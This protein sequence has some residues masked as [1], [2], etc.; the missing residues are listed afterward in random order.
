[1]IRKTF[2]AG[3][4]ALLLCSSANAAVIVG[5]LLNPASTAGVTVSTRSGPGSWQLY[6]IEDAA[7]TDLGISG[8][9]VTMTNTT[10][11]N[12]RSPTGSEVNTAGDTNPWGFSNLRSGTNANP[13][14]ASQPLPTTDPTAPVLITGFGREAN[15]A[16]AKILLADPGAT[17]IT[18]STGASWGAY[19]SP[20]L[21]NAATLLAA[22]PSASAAATAMNAGRKWVFLA[23]GLGTTE[24][25]GATSF[26]VYTAASG[27]STATLSS[28]QTLVEVPE[29]A[30]LSLLGLAFVG[31]LGVIRRRRNG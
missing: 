17:S 16:N 31:G 8:Y 4:A 27:V 5:L 28:V 20:V 30:T 13:I 1:M 3:L 25:V 14:V 6:A 12:H 11:I 24:G 9:S 26:T 23:E 19:N 29:P 15:N 10:A 21:N 22:N 2:L 7:A 18:A